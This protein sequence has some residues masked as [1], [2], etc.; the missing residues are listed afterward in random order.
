MPYLLAA[1]MVLI[2]INYDTTASPTSSSRQVP[3]ITEQ[4]STT[5]PSH[6]DYRNIQNDGEFIASS[7]KQYHSGEIDLDNDLGEEDFQRNALDRGPFFEV[8]ATKNITAIA[9]H[10]AYLNCRVRNLG[11][12]TVSWIRHRDL[13]LLTVG[14]ETYTPDQRFQSVHNPHNDDWALKV[15]YPQQKDSGIYEC[16]IS[17][18]PPVGYSVMFSVV[19][20]TTTILGMPE[21]YIDSGSTVNLTCI[22]HG[23]NEPPTAIQWTHNG[24][25]INYDSPRGGVSVITEKSDI[26]TSYLLIQRAKTADSGKYT[27]SPSHANSV[28]IL[29]HVLNSEHPAAIQ[30]A[31]RIQIKLYLLCFTIFSYVASST[32]RLH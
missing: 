3:T 23:L 13:H 27:C 31:D 1:I 9:G 5:T 15:L 19:E 7:L 17:T 28:G 26:T 25:E 2:S 20:P 21:M 18:T 30:R 8:S 4:V 22:V 24:Y 29:V 6:L 16:Q 11:N 32:K 14:K 10:S 12:R